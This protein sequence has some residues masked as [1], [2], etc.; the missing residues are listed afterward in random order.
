MSESVIQSVVDSLE[1]TDG[2]MIK[3]R[4][5]SGSRKTD[6]ASLG[7]LQNLRG[8]DSTSAKSGG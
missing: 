2:K 3:G 5:P 6:R 4:I 7:A 1:K 8:V